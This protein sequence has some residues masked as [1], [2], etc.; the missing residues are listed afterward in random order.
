MMNII[1]KG[2]VLIYTIACI[3]GL[4]LAIVISWEFVDW[5]R[6]EPRIVRGGDA[7]GGNDMRIASEFDKSKAVFEIAKA[8]RDL[9][10]LPPA[11]AEASLREAQDHFAQNHLFYVA[12]LRKLEK[13]P[14]DIDVKRL[15]PEG[16][17]TDTPGKAI[18]KPVP[19][20]KIAD[21]NKSLATYT[22]MLKAEQD[23]IGPI[24]EAVGDLAKKNSD[25]S[26]QL[27]GKDD[28]GAKVTH[29]LFELVDLEFNA[30]QRLLQEYEYVQPQWASMVEEARRYSGRRSSLEDTLGGLDKAL[31]AR[32]A[33]RK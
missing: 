7:K 19:S 20:V 1:G 22:A 29:G 26:Y 31:K 12:Q 14:G 8:G 17:P 16:I 3:A 30:Q 5:G 21:L 32:E 24:E 33:K 28:K 6:S 23:K 10:V 11:P 15:P 18:G 27:T 25:I 2:L 13:D 4:I 9:V